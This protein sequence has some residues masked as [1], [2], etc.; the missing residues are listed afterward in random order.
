MAESC[1]RKGFEMDVEKRTSDFKRRTSADGS[2]VRCIWIVYFHLEDV[3]GQAAGLIY[4]RRGAESAEITEYAY[5]YD[6]IGNRLSSLDIGTNRTLPITTTVKVI[7]MNV[8][9]RGGGGRL[10]Y[11]FLLFTLTCFR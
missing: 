2:D 9:A 4:S 3:R 10:A 11:N 6:D 8:P 5:A 7:E 1:L